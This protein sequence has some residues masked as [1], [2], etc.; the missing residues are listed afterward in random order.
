MAKTH[1]F[2]FIL[3]CSSET[4]FPLFETRQ[5]SWN[6]TL[7]FSQK[8]ENW[9]IFTSVNISRSPENEVR[10]VRTG[11]WNPLPYSPALSQKLA[12]FEGV[13]LNAGYVWYH[14]LCVVLLP[15]SIICLPELFFFFISL[16][17]R[18]VLGRLSWLAAG[19]VSLKYISSMG[20]R[21]FSHS[22]LL[23]LT[24]TYGWGRDEGTYTLF[25]A[26]YSGE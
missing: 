16:L 9:T 13:S 21:P 17:L 3:L 12:T 4:T 20:K 23:Q 6:K 5:K 19:W 2:K 25:M 24:D 11:F 8:T 14:S 1:Q 10:G 18:L 22:P 7:N 15:I 26:V